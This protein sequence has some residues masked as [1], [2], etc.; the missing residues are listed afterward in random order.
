M[1]RLGLVGVAAIVAL[2]PVPPELVESVY[3][4]RVYPALQARVTGMSN[5]VPVAL[6][7]LLLAAVT[8]GSVALAW[9]DFRRRAALVALAR[10]ARRAVTLAAVLYLGFTVLW[11]FN[12]QRIPLEEKLDLDYRAATPQATELLAQRAVAEM[13]RLYRE[14]RQALA[15]RPDRPDP[16]L[17]GALTAA[18]RELG[19]ETPVVAARPKRTILDAYFRAASIDGM[20]D[21]FFLETLTMST[22]LP[23]ERPMVLAHEWAHL[24]GYADEG[25]ANFVGWLACLRG[26]AAAQYSAWLFLY[27]EA[28][29]GLDRAAR[30]RVAAALEE[31]PRADLRAIAARIRSQVQPT[32]SALGW[33]V[34]DQ[35]LKAN[36][37]E[38]GRESYTDVVRLVLGTSLGVRRSGV[39]PPS[40]V[41]TRTGTSSGSPL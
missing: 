26:D 23:V 17:A 41:G 20:T 8:I 31:G 35:Y 34:Y 30:I 6:F 40:G 4:G 11:G 7:D 13:N 21:P 14:P 27:S 9:R 32:L 25:E 38:R 19:R 2:V 39:E 10:L 5:A 36:G 37:V 3:A 24:A 12:Y 33:G 22:L 29:V 16:A 15:D 1:W 28:A 18:A